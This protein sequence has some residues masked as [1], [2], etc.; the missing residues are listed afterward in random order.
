MDGMF[1]HKNQTLSPQNSIA[2]RYAVLHVAN[3]WASSGRIFTTESAESAESAEEEGVRIKDM[4]TLLFRP[5]CSQCLCG[6]GLCGAGG[7]AV[8]PSSGQ[9]CLG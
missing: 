6:E 9:A 4:K 7:V 8:A 2:A 1:W 3:G 5:P